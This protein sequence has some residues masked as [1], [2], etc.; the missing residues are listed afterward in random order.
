MFEALGKQGDV[1]LQANTLAG[2]DQVL[3][4]DVTEVGVV[5][6]QIAEFRALLDEVDGA[7]ALD[8]VMETA[9]TDQFA[10][11]HARVVKT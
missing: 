11:H 1:V 4:A 6:D 7:K 10:Q 8:F 2:L 9:K 5:Q 3:L